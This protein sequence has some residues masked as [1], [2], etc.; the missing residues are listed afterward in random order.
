MA[1]NFHGIDDEEQDKIKKEEKVDNKTKESDY[2][3]VNERTEII[4]DETFPIIDIVRIPEIPEKGSSSCGSDSNSSI[5]TKSKNSI[6]ESNPVDDMD[7]GQEKLEPLEH[8]TIQSHK[9]EEQNEINVIPVANPCDDEKCCE[10][11]TENGENTIQIESN[12]EEQDHDSFHE[13]KSLQNSVTT[14]SSN[15]IIEDCEDDGT[16]DDETKLQTRMPISVPSALNTFRQAA[17]LKKKAS[18]LSR[19]ASIN[20]SKQKLDVHLTVG[21]RLERLEECQQNMK[22]RLSEQIMNR[23]NITYDID[24]NFEKRLKVVENFLL[25]FGVVEVNNLGKSDEM[26]NILQ[27]KEEEEENDPGRVNIKKHNLIDANECESIDVRK[28]IYPDQLKKSTVNN[29]ILGQC[30]SSDFITNENHSSSLKQNLSK[31]VIERVDTNESQSSFNISSAIQFDSHNLKIDNIDSDLK[32]CSSKESVTKSCEHAQSDKILNSHDLKDGESIMEDKIHQNGTKLCTAKKSNAL[33]NYYHTRHSSL[34]SHLNDLDTKTSER[35]D[36]LA[37]QL[38]EF[39]DKIEKRISRK[40]VD[41]IFEKISLASN[42]NN[43]SIVSIKEIEDINDSIHELGNR[44]NDMVSKSELESIIH[45]GL[46]INIDC[47]GN[48]GNNYGTTDILHSFKIHMEDKLRYLNDTKL[49]MS[50]I[51]EKFSLMKKNFSDD[52]EIKLNAQKAIIQNSSDKLTYDVG[53]CRTYIDALDRKIEQIAAQELEENSELDLDERIKEVTDTVHKSLH[54]TLS[55]KLEDVQI[56]EDELV[57]I[58]SQIADRPD[59]N[60]VVNMLQDL[61]EALSDRVGNARTL[62]MILNNLKIGE[63]FLY[64]FV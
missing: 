62:Q 20:I 28:N 37:R 58:A 47:D 24:D 12:I 17:M 53:A 14:K 48:D 54:E 18:T 46:N 56:I 41:N 34:I 35:I 8:Q 60:Q 6:D 32:T 64:F 10:E 4:H 36:L 5:S 45:A 49:E 55:K 30:V 44:I 61:E 11:P 51:T 42:Q 21:N 15:T 3:E 59:Q 13:S 31:A 23:N 26:D 63:T 52:I 7:S 29:E 50:D 22:R 33:S 40:S 43:D 1:Y 39:G 2:D 9:K 27:Q 19:R 38:H 57:R 16:C 25:G